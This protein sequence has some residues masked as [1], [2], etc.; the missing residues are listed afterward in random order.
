MSATI[1]RPRASAIS[2]FHRR[3]DRADRID[4]REPARLGEVHR[5]RGRR[6]RHRGERAALRRGR[7]LRRVEREP[8][9]SAF[10][11][12][13]SPG[14]RVATAVPRGEKPPSAGGAHG[15]VAPGVHVRCSL[16]AS[17][18]GTPLRAAHRVPGP[19][20]ALERVR[21]ARGVRPARCAEGV[22]SARRVAARSP[23]RAPS[24]SARRRRPRRRADRSR[25]DAAR[26]RRR[27]GRSH[28][29]FGRDTCRPRRQRRARGE[30]DRREQQ[31]P[32]RGSRSRAPAPRPRRPCE[33]LSPRSTSRRGASRRSPRR[34]A[35]N[36]A[37]IAGAFPGSAARD[38]A[39]IE[40]AARRTRRRSAAGR[41]ANS[42]AMEQLG[43]CRA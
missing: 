9:G 3:L 19:L 39:R 12:V 20:G 30:R 38:P 24:S 1:L 13:G 6:Q 11:P 16:G 26:T 31:S 34:P 21:A 32:S 41:R 40:R 5:R 36:A 35:S 29:A 10:G 15:A 37:A 28:H 17:N 4:G 25:A 27:T 23:V 7:R 33:D 22:R 2:T 42:V 18:A 43:R 8:S 14:L